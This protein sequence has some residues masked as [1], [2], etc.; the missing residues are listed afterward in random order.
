MAALERRL[1]GSRWTDTDFDALRERHYESEGPYESE[2]RSEGERRSESQPVYADLDEDR[3]V[4]EEAANAGSAAYVGRGDQAAPGRVS[5][6]SLLPGRRSSEELIDEDKALANCKP[7]STAVLS[8]SREHARSS[9][10]APRSTPASPPPR[11]RQ[12]GLRAPVGDAATSAR[13]SRLSSSLGRSSAPLK[14]SSS[15]ETV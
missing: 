12:A 8:V 7:L 4:A 15:D 2:G 9:R 10:F 6:R 13:S 5:F 3:P 14:S 11:G 1:A